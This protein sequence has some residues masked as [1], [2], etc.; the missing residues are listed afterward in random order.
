MTTVPNHQYFSARAKCLKML[1][2]ADVQRL[3]FGN[4]LALCYTSRISGGEHPAIFTV[5]GM[6]ACEALLALA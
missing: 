4:P 3:M 6:T 5:M 1:R 2:S